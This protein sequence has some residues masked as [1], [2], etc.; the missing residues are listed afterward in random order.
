MEKNAAPSGKAIRGSRK[1]YVRPAVVKA[2]A[3]PEV[4]ALFKQSNVQ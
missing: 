4:T 3:L 1:R 2:M